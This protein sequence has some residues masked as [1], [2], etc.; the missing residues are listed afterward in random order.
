MSED[1]KPKLKPRMPQRSQPPTST[2]AETRLDGE[3]S[4]VELLGAVR[5][6]QSS[7]D[8]LTDPQVNPG[9]VD[10]V[11]RGQHGI[12]VDNPVLQA[13]LDIGN[14][15][16]YDEDE[17]ARLE[18]VNRLSVPGVADAAF[19][20]APNLR[21]DPVAGEFVEETRTAFD[22][23]AAE[24]YT[25]AYRFGEKWMP[26]DAL[27]PIVHA[28]SGGGRKAMDD[29]G[30]PGVGEERPELTRAE[31]LG[32]ARGRAAAYLAALGLRPG[33]ADVVASHEPTRP[34]PALRQ[35]PVD[36]DA[37]PA[38]LREFIRELAGSPRR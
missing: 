28:V 10:D 26:P 22:P 20:D 19:A 13:A 16:R 8:P 25:S 24:R 37:T 21:R 3:P 2:P 6:L 18:E 7:V 1:K 5:P 36:I 12:I 31:G 32:M 34:H 30:I 33:D 9:D 38:E 11:G 27:L 35:S 4:L 29:L 15:G 23:A 14:V 17:A